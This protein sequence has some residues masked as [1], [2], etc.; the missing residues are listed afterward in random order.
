MPNGEAPR[1]MK[2]ILKYS[3]LAALILSLSSCGL[4]MALGRS[5]GSLVNS[6]GGLLN[7]A[8]AL[9]GAL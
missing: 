8:G 7:S 9:G 6:A 1:E 2:R 3:A 5:A 4:P